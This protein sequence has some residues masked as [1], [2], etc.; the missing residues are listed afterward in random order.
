MIGAQIDRWAS[1]YAAHPLLE[2][3][4]LQPKPAI[5]I[6]MYHSVS[7]DREAG[8]SSSYRLVTSP[9]RFREQ[10]QHLYERKFK[11]IGLSDVMRRLG[12]DS[13]SM[14]RTV[15]LTF[16]DGFDDFRTSAWPVLASF[17]FTATMFLPTAFVGRSS[18][19]FQG[20]TCLT[21]SDV[22]A[23]H[24]DGVSFGAHTIHHPVLYR[25]PWADIKRELHDSRKLIQEE[26]QACIDLFAYP[27][28]F[29][30]EDRV[31]VKRFTREIADAGYRTAVTTVIGRARSNASPL[32][33]KRLPIS[34]RDDL[35]LFHSKL[36]GA[37]DWVGRIQLWARRSRNPKAW[38]SR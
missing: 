5:P 2:A 3:G 21:W 16:D 33:L 23:L 28:A 26:L 10:M 35:A 1:V 14:D 37:Y 27:Y 20:R 34:E 36:V 12:T 7:N 24:K 11:V 25:M 31:F 8:V 17:G 30:Q 18:L 32:T 13:S 9:A 6:L 4:L 19:S 22:R 29:P 38:I 15:V